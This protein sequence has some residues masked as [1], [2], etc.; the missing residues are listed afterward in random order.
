MLS[1]LPLATL[2]VLIALLFSVER[3][4][5]PR[6]TPWQGLILLA[7]SIWG[8]L[9]LLISE[10]LSLVQ[11]ITAINLTVAWLVVFLPLL[12][13][14]I[15]LRRFNQAWQKLLG[16]AKNISRFEI[17]W[18]LTI[19]LLLLLLLVVGLK[20]PPNMV[21]VMNYHMPRVSHWAQAQEIAHFATP[22]PSQNSKP[23]W[24]E[25]VILNLRVLA[26]SDTPAS[27]L[28]WMSLI[29]TM[30]A[31]SGVVKELGGDRSAQWLGAV[32]AFAVPVALLQVTT[33]KNDVVASFWV[34]ALVYYALLNRR[35]E[36]AP[37]EF[38]GLSL[39]L[40]L[41]MLTKGTFFLY[42]PAIL[43][44]FFLQRLLKQ[45]LKQTLI[46]GTIMAAI[47]ISLN[48]PYLVRN[49]QTYGSPFGRFVP[50]E[51]P[52]TTDTD[53]GTLSETLIKPTTPVAPVVMASF[54]P[55]R[56]DSTGGIAQRQ[57]IL[58]SVSERVVEQLRRLVR[59]VL[60][61]FVSPFSWF[62]QR[63]FTLLESWPILFP[64]GNL[65]PLKQA[66]WNHAL[67]AGNPLHITLALLSVFPVT[68]WAFLKK[69]I[70]LAEYWLVCLS[71]FLATSFVSC[72]DGVFCLR[73][74]LPFITLMSALIAVVLSVV[75]LN[76]VRSMTLLFIIYAIPY[77]LINN[78]RPVIGMPPWPT[79]IESVFV[80]DPVE[81]LFA[82]R[83][84]IEDEYV[85][86]T[87]A[88]KAQDCNAVGL[89]L[90]RFDLEYPFWWLLE[91]PQSGVRIENL[92]T[93]PTS[94][95][96]IDESF[97]PCAI[98]CTRGFCLGR[99]KMAGLPL[100]LRSGHVQLFL[101]S[102]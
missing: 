30:V 27:L 39:A 11:G 70:I 59:M 46:T 53:R 47:A 98:I 34:A 72:A 86:M 93:T 65:D 21:D 58:G 37:H 23:Y 14:L 28:S 12:I 33:P 32:C 78:M 99:D 43:A 88:I 68:L 41:G 63:F 91:A 67:T 97:K 73:Y 15:R 40:G 9:I 71:G 83:P 92:Q 26:G 85:L 77:V 100:V 10:G 44:W 13:Y 80:A 69:K 102:Q 36:L 31:V 94:K 60:M 5:K 79:R 101:E 56:L 55:G 66:A 6:V 4:E 89:A 50:V 38:L 45:G 7:V 95:Q 57:T 3:S 87:D 61:N 18:V 81:I 74:Q 22:Q 75:G 64:S 19:G 52:V 42:A 20:T 29:G 54:L 48:V 96:Y 24:A 62:N 16:I 25:L 76:L 17:V 35:R 90:Y 82:A 1:L 84:G 49:F 51:L 2:G 8:V